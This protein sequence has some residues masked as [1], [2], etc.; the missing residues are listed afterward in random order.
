VKR[1]CDHKS[2][3]FVDGRQTLPY[4][5]MEGLPL[6]HL[7][8]PAKLPKFDFPSACRC[9]ALCT[10][11]Q[12]FGLHLLKQ[13]AEKS[14]HTLSEDSQPIRLHRELRICYEYNVQQ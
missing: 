4:P 13:S 11:A 8:S 14:G 7:Q 10:C 3:Q 2:S 9:V 6:I 12:S 1:S 5:F